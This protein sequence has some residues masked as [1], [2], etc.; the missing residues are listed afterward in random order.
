MHSHETVKTSANRLQGELKR[1]NASGSEQAQKSADEPISLLGRDVLK[2][3][4]RTDKVELTFAEFRGLDEGYVVQS[5]FVRIPPCVF[6]NRRRDIATDHS[7]RTARQRDGETSGTASEVENS[8][9]R[10]IVAEGRGDRGKQ[11]RDVFLTTLQKFEVANPLIGQDRKVRLALR[12][13]FPLSAIAILHVRR[14]LG[15]YTNPPR[16]AS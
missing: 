1:E 7:R 15:A 4:Q 13:R 9:Q 16:S 14:I 2:R 12:K 3:E 5:G 6:E 10:N 8:R 11:Q